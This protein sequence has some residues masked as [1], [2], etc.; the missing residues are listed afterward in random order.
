MEKINL[1]TYIIAF[2]L[3]FLGIGSYYITKWTH[4]YFATI[5]V[6]VIFIFWFINTSSILFYKTLNTNDE[7]LKYIFSFLHILILTFAYMILTAKV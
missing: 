1:K 3:F 6:W 4:S 7:Y 2:L 5:F